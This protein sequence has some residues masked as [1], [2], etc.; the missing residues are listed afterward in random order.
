MIVDPLRKE[1]VV[2]GGR[3]NAMMGR[4][5]RVMMKK[6]DLVERVLR[7]RVKIVVERGRRSLRVKRRRRLRGKPGRRRKG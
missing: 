2:E 1:A 5:T 6:E 4:F 3:A 7:D